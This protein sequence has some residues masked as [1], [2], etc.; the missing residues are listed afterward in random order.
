MKGN[1]VQQA[2]IGNDGLHRINGDQTGNEARDQ[3][4]I[5]DRFGNFGIG[6][7][8]EHRQQIGDADG[9]QYGQN[10]DNDCVPN[11]IT[12]ELVGDE[13]NVIIKGER[14]GFWVLEGTDDLVDHRVNHQ[15]DGNQHSRRQ[16]SYDKKRRFPVAFFRFHSTLSFQQWF[17]GQL[18]VI[19]CQRS[20]VRYI[21]AV[22]ISEYFC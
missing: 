3:I 16:S 9:Q 1:A 12:G 13:V 22:W 18:S 4:K 20:V 2:G 17:S 21:P 19:G 5:P 6:K 15:P 8:E 7:A 14:S 10:R 11:R